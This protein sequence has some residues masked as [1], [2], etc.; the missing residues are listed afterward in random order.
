MRNSVYPQ[1]C[2]T[3]SLLCPQLLW[4]LLQSS[5]PRLSPKL[6]F[7]FAPL[8]P[9][10]GP[11]SLIFRGVNRSFHI[12]EIHATGNCLFL[13]VAY[14]WKN[15]IDETV[16]LE[17]RKMA[18]S[19]VCEHWDNYGDALSVVL[20]HGSTIIHSARQYAAYMNTSGVYGGE[21]EIV[22]MSQILP[23]TIAIYFRERQHDPPRVYNPGQRLSISLLFSGPLD[24][25]HYEVLLPFRNTRDELL[26]T[27]V[28]NVGMC[29]NITHPRD[30]HTDVTSPSHSPV[31][32]EHLQTPEFHCNICSKQF[33]RKNN[34]KAHL[35]THPSQQTHSTEDFKCTICS[36]TFRLQRYLNA[37]FK[38]HP[39]RQIYLYGQIYHQ[40]SP[41][42]TNPNT[43]SRYGQL[44]IF[45]SA[46][47]TTQRLQ[48]DC[49]SACS[50][51]LLLQLDKMI[52]QVNPFSKSYMQMHDIITHSN[53]V[54]TVRMVF[55]ENPTVDMR[56]YNAPF[57]Q[58]DVDAIFVGED[59]EPPAQRDICIYPRGDA[60]K[61]ISVLNMNCDPMVYP[62]LFPYGDPGW[63]IQ[64]AHV[65]EKRT[66]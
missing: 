64:L 30:L 8:F 4:Y 40:V 33:T 43:T 56:R 23:A 41:L 58:T 10:H 22:A 66:A 51:M 31:T 49:N 47:A 57:C 14:F 29:T 42:Y 18:V 16:A 28:D 12:V 13:S 65:E 11:A 3:Q 39:S 34:L 63:H 53:H 46:E 24:H 60:C 21:A 25:G 37:H 2:V 62:L 54:T 27:S 48:N 20:T 44:Y 59:G 1:Q 17:L 26:V 38:T 15:V 7:D 32:D 5:E 50:G 9:N 45:D 36:K 6:C 35:E 19:F 55:M 61:R 52:R